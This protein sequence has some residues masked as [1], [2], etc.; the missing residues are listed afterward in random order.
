MISYYHLKTN[1]NKKR[2]VQNQAEIEPKFV[3]IGKNRYYVHFKTKK[4][5][6]K[7]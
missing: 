3:K 2:D 4:M 6:K 5:D 7:I 1:W